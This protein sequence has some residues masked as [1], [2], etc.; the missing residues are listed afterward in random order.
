MVPDKVLQPV[1][2]KISTGKS[3]GTDIGKTWYRKKVS[4][5]VSVKFGTG[6]DFCCQNFG[7]QK[8]SSGYRNW[9]REFLIFSDGIGTGMGKIWYRKKVSEPVSVKIGIGKKSRNRYRKNLVPKKS[10]GI[11]IE[12]IWYRKKVSVSV[13]FN[14]SGTVTH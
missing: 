11:G 3:L 14:I 13:S 5:P 6:A 1:S 9:Y 12:N 8:I 2:E 4:E 10:T 7:I